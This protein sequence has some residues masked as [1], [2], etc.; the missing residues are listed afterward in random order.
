MSQCPY[1]HRNLK[2]V[3]AAA[4][5]PVIL[6]TRQ[7]NSTQLTPWPAQA[8]PPQAGEWEKVTPVGKMDI[9]DVLTSVLDAA[10]S[11]GLVTAGTSIVV[12]LADWHWGV[13]PIT[14]LVVATWRYFGGIS[15]T[16]SLLYTIESWTHTD[17]NH[18]G[19]TGQPSTK[20]EPVQLEIIHK[21]ERGNLIRAQLPQLPEEVSLPDFGKWCLALAGGAPISEDRWVGPGQPFTKTQYRELL[22]TMS[23]VGIIRKNGEASNSKWVISPGKHHTLGN[24]S[25]VCLAASVCDGDSISPGQS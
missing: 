20:V 23:S 6:Q 19:V 17:L 21:N 18:D 1:C 5:H 11:F 7:F 14:G 13:G 24:W 9:G 22:K 4:T 3:P 10:V 12:Y 8:E 2:I 15:A 25:N 16:R